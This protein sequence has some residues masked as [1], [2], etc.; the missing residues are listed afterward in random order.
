[1]LVHSILYYE[2]NTNIVP[3]PTF[4]AWAHELAALQLAHPVESASVEY[5][6]DEFKDWTGDGGSH[7]P[8]R[9]PRAY[10]IALGL[11]KPIGN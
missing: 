9:D 2:M 5:M 11:T 8:L 4:D 6:R 3:D 10:A 7:L 1:M